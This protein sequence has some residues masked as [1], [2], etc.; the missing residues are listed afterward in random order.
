MQDFARFGLA[1][2]VGTLIDLI[3]IKQEIAYSSLLLF[4][5]ACGLLI[6]G[7]AGDFTLTFAEPFC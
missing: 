3:W 4:I 7:T 2:G 5:L 1:V 6:N